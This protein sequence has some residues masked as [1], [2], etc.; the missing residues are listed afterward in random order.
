MTKRYRLKKDL[1]TFKAGDEFILEDDALYA[2][3]DRFPEG[4][5]RAYM[6][7]TLEAYPNILTDWFEEIPEGPKTV[8]GLE[9][10]DECWIRDI[11]LEPGKVEWRDTP[12][13][14][15]LR[16][17]GLVFLSREALEKDDARRKAKVILERDTKGFKPN[18]ED[19][20]NKYGVYYDY[21]FRELDIEYY[22]TCCSHSNLWF[23][24]SKDAKA[25][26]KN[27]EKEWKIYLGVE[28]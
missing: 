13:D 8:F 21:E 3:G 18:W 19:V 28:E 20:S 1:P 14:N 12:Y 2:I 24:S 15:Q 26:I 7:R 4:K 11:D 17:L 16:N 22:D 27:H 6:K 23:E 25:S 10:G 5:I 9:D